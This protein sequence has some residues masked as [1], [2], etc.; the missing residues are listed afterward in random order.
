MLR[1]G[2]QWK[3]STSFSQNAVVTL[4]IDDQT[5]AG[6]AITWANDS[7]HVAIANYDILQVWDVFAR[8][9]LGSMKFQ[10]TSQAREYT[11]LAW[12]PDQRFIAAATV[13][14]AQIFEVATG[15][16]QS[17]WGVGAS[18]SQNASWSSDS[19]RVVTAGGENGT[20]V[21]IHDAMTGK[22]LRSFGGKPA[23]NASQTETYIN[24]SLSPDN[25][26]LAADGFDDFGDKSQPFLSIW[27]ISSGKQIFG[28]YYAIGEG[29]IQ[30]PMMLAWSPDSSRI[31]TA[32]NT[33]GVNVWDV[34][35]ERLV[36]TYV[37]T[38]GPFYRLAWSPDGK[39]IACG[40]DNVIRIWDVKTGLEH[41]SYLGHANFIQGLSW[42]RVGNY[43][44]SI[45]NGNVR[46]WQP[47]LD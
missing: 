39:Y 30:L 33:A 34:L 47:Q 12:S 25:L 32:S 38:G 3:T 29:E 9:Q 44:A 40:D 14:S 26:Y 36:L 35:M 31:A 10:P 20:A 2:E 17:S 11:S 42:S 22:L 23:L 19:Q 43:I 6:K 18:F 37:G 8:K 5:G 45:S 28:T 24:V 13:G 4:P 21:E 7:R 46:I 27:S 41:F 15:K 16:L 1:Y